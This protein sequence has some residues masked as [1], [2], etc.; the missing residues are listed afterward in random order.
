[1]KV[2]VTDSG[3]A[4]LQVERDVLAGLDVEFTAAQCTTEEELI[5][6]LS[7]MDYLIS[8]YA[9]ITARVIDKFDRCRV[10]SRYGVGVDNID[11]DAAAAAGI[12]VCNVPDYC[13]DEVADH[14][15]ALL[16]DLT[17]RIF[18]AALDA[19]SYTHLTLPTKA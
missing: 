19:V 8:Q 1:M 7:E 17:R 4:D 5:D 10:I 12:A 3:F 6:Q 2:A 18:P 14:A 13:I 15:L 9:P 16:L 11:L